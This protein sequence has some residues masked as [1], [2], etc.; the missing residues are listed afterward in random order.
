[1]PLRTVVT[2][3]EVAVIRL[4]H[5]DHHYTHSAWSRCS[6]CGHRL[7]LWYCFSRRL[8]G[9]A[10]QAFLLNA[11]LWNLVAPGIT[12]LFI[13]VMLP[14][15]LYRRGRAQMAAETESTDVQ[16]RGTELRNR[17]RSRRPGSRKGSKRKGG[18][19]GDTP[20]GTRG[21]RP[22]RD[23]KESSFASWKYIA[24]GL[25][26]LFTAVILSEVASADIVCPGS[27]GRARTIVLGLVVGL[28]V[29]V[30][31]TTLLLVGVSLTA[32]FFD[33]QHGKDASKTVASTTARVRYVDAG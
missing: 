14:Y 17:Q 13:C 23:A 19:K 32:P 31:T 25:A 9:V 26:I 5:E 33:T 21:S 28:P 3:I 6:H 15:S 10:V 29:G 18:G 11:N 16:S 4:G 30:G 27:Q 2:C 8:R 22:E 1:M 20:T 7:P 24:A 12:C